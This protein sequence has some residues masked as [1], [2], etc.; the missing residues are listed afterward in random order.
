MQLTPRQV[1]MQFGHL[2]QTELFPHLET[3]V[4]PLT[5]QLELLSSVMALV[6]LDRLLSGNRARTG[7]PP[8]TGSPWPR[9]SSPRPSS[10]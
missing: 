5:P 6:P 8:R 10:I 4:G 3:A 7:R 9:P 1:L 2:L